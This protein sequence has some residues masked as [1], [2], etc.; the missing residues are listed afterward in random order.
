[1]KNF[2]LSHVDTCYPDYLVDHHNREG[3]ALFGVYLGLLSEAVSMPR[4]AAENRANDPGIEENV[5]A[6]VALYLCEK[7]GWTGR[8]AMYFFVWVTDENTHSTGRTEDPA[9]H[10]ARQNVQRPGA[11]TKWLVEYEVRD[12]GAIG[13]FWLKRDIVDADT[14]EQATEAFRVKYREKYEFR[15]PVV[16]REVQ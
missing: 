11:P 8:I 12:L 7:Q 13:V 10:A 6:A 16:V 14:S 9:E 5:H 2:D 4:V 15:S 1:M 3:E